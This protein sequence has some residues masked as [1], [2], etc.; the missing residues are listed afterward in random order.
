MAKWYER[1]VLYFLP[2]KTHESEDGFVMYKMFWNRIYIYV[3]AHYVYEKPKPFD[4][5]HSAPWSN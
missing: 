4:A 2:Y 1:V 5:G 3:H